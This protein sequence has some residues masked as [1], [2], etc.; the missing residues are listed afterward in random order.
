MTFARP[1]SAWQPHLPPT[2]LSPRQR[3]WLSDEGSL[4]ARLRARYPQFAVRLLRQQLLQPA[5]D[6]RTALGVRDRQLAWGR[7][8]LLL[9]AQAPRIYARSLL[10]CA[11]ARGPWQ[12]FAEV[13]NRSLGAVLFADP[14]I[15]RQP[16]HYRRVDQRHALYRAAIAASGLCASEVPQ[17]W[18]RRSLFRRQG[19]VLMVSEV[20]L[21]AVF[22]S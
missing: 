10:P 14:R 4:T 21:P 12:M 7:E 22:E 11:H 13:G 18:A 6:E 5:L 20:F 3:R 8:V 1:A 17:L 2:S 9:A 19:Q 16:L 15:E